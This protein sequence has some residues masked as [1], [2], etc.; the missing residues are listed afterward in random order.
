M[1]VSIVNRSPLPDGF[2]GIP[3]NV[4]IRL[5]AGG[6]PQPFTLTKSSGTLPDGLDNTMPIYLFG[7][8]PIIPG[9]TI[10]E[11]VVGSVSN[12]RGVVFNSVGGLD[13]GTL[14]GTFLP[15]TDI[16][17]GESSGSIASLDTAILAP[18]YANNPAFRP[19]LV[20]AGLYDDLKWLISGTPTKLGTFTFFLRTYD[21]IQNQITFGPYTITIRKKSSVKAAGLFTKLCFGRRYDITQDPPILLP[22]PEQIIYPSPFGQ[23]YYLFSSDDKQ[24]CYVKQPPKQ[25]NK[26]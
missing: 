1:S 25:L 17:T 12:A 8:T 21:V 23:L 10:G 3:Y 18:Q 6:D 7:I 15:G 19:Q 5:L 26:S 20:P 16:L 4:D 22:C 2:L 11:T 9:I 14:S 24:C 13:V